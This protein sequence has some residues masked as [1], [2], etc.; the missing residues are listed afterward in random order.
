MLDTFTFLLFHAIGMRYLEALFCSFIGIM[1]MCFFVDLGMIQPDVSS[2][3]TQGFRPAIPE[4]AIVQAIGMIGAI[5]MPH[6][7][8]LH[9]ALVQSRKINPQNSAHVS[10][11]NRY[12]A[13]ESAIALIMS[14]FINVSVLV[15][16]ATA[17]YA[18][19]CAQNPGL[20]TACVPQ[21]VAR[22]SNS[23]IY[24]FHDGSICNTHDNC[25]P[26]YRNFLPHVSGDPP[27]VCQEIGLSDA[28]EAVTSVLGIYARRFWALG[29]LISGQASTMTGTLAGQYVMEGFLGWKIDPWKRVALTRSIALLPAVGVAIASQARPAESD[30]VNEWLNVLQSLQLPFALI[31]LM[32]FGTSSRLMGS[33]QTSIYLKY[34][35]LIVSLVVLGINFGLVGHFI[36][37]LEN[38]EWP[39]LIALTLLGMG[40]ATLLMSLVRTTN[41]V[42]EETDYHL[43]HSDYH[44]KLLQ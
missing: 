4:Y 42:G 25:P 17:F 24:N 20:M 18:P 29:L 7:L 31:P 12:F 23:P 11:A 6:N 36:L 44:Q 26:C 34:L 27:Y 43:N 1:F 9:S 41:V 15:V 16:F 2:I 37:K 5:I 33:F 14:F 38:L 39:T 32:M 35:I 22:E 8:Y 21:S 30:R 28:G 13:I 3:V 19:E 40:Y 10:E